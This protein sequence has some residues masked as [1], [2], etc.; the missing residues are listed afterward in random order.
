MTKRADL[1]MH[2]VFVA[3]GSLLVLAAGFAMLGVIVFSVR[4]SGLLVLS[5]LALLILPLVLYNRKYQ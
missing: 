5:L 4:I 3:L 2:M 1:V